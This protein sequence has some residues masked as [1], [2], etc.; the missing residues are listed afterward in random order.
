MPDITDEELGELRTQAASAADL[1]TQLAAAQAQAA[2]ALRD[3]AVSANPDVPPE[4]IT[5]ATPEE[6]SASLDR[7]KAIVE[8]I[9]Q[10][11]IE[12]LRAEA[13]ATKPPLGFNPPALRAH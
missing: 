6:L 9:R 10:A 7:G 3:A 13:G 1:Q 11:T 12:A 8:S 4:L 5:G 2:T